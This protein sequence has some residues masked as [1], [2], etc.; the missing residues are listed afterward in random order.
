MTETADNTRPITD[1]SLLVAGN[2]MFTVSSP[3]GDRYTYLVAYPRIAKLYYKDE[4][5]AKTDLEKFKGGTL[6]KD[7]R[8]PES[9]QRWCAEQKTDSVIEVGIRDYQ[10]T[11]DKHDLHYYRLHAPLYVNV[12][13]GPDNDL[14]YSYAGIWTGGTLKLTKNSRF[15]VK[16]R[17]EGDWV[18]EVDWPK[19]QRME[20]IAE[21][22]EKIG[23]EPGPR[24]S[25]SIRVFLWTLWKINQGKGLPEGYEIRH[26]GRC[27][28][29][30]RTLTV[31]TSI[32]MGLGPVCADKVLG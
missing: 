22:N 1:P 25:G 16:G 3:S 26:A 10:D 18:N 11:S 7:T 32:D 6:T 23:Q 21:A 15:N 17:F 2:A 24:L 12:L 30:G 13:T 20:K 29:C 27:C 14:D 31:P 5:T 4:D 9:R 28:R 19:A 8:S